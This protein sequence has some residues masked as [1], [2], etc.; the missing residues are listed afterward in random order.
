MRSANSP[1]TVE[2]WASLLK[3]NTPGAARIGMPVFVAQGESD[4]LVKPAVTTQYVT[5]RCATGEHV[6]YRQYPGADHGSTAGVA[7][8]D[9]LPFFAAT[10]KGGA[11]AAT[12]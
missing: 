8:K 6:V 2:P 7:I 3:Q 9:V 10:L 1:A 5:G 11:P 12:C 4:A